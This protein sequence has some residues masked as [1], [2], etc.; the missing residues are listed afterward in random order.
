MDA[1]DLTIAR[2]PALAKLQ[3][4]RGTRDILPEDMRR[5]RAVVEA[6]RRLAE[7]Y[8]YHEMA[9]PVFEFT[10]VFKRTLGETSDIV[11]KEMYTFP[12]SEEGD[13]VTL[14]PEAPAASVENAG[15][16]NRSPPL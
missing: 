4:V 3:P 10:D 2:R 8:G 9:T 16:T 6:C 7:R 15:R 12:V 1:R 5:Q 11:T 13:S 14:R